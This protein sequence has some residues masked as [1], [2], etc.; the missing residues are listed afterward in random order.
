M[1]KLGKRLQQIESLVTET[2]DHI[3]D[4]CCDHGLLGA[5]LLARKN[6]T[7]QGM[8]HFVD[9]VPALMDELHQ[10]LSQFYPLDKSTT[11]AQWKTHCLDVKQ[12]P[13]SQYPGK[14]LVIIAGVGG[15]L[16]REFVVAICNA[17][18]QQDIDFLLCPVHHQYTL[19]SQLIKLKMKLK[20]ECL[21]EENKRF[22]EIMLVSTNN[23]HDTNKEL[24][25]IHLT[26]QA[27][28]Q[29]QNQLQ[30]KVVQNYLTKTL[31]HYQRMQLSGAEHAAKILED[32]QRINLK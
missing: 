17:F 4:C 1:L 2:Y 5:A 23:Q 11:H 15:D 16:T 19:R 30:H 10:K 12:L 21:I 9:I 25:D 28:W 14:Q 27:I 32:Y 18:P 24:E 3:W 20:Q 13:L 31:K 22:Y 7:D 8:I 29:S 26:G 6:N